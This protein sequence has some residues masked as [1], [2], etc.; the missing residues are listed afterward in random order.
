M[1]PERKR[2]LVQGV[3]IES[4]ASSDSYR[5]STLILNRSGK[6]QNVSVSLRN[7]P[8]TKGTIRLYTIDKKHNSYLDGANEKLTAQ[9]QWSDVT[10]SDWKWSGQMA[11]KS[12]L[13]IE[14]EDGTGASD[15]PSN[16]VAKIIRVNRYYPAR[17][18]RSYSDFDARTWI[19]RQGMN[20]E[21]LA[22]QQVGVTAKA[23][24]H[25]LVVRCTVNGQ[26]PRQDTNSLLGLRLDYDTARGYHKGVLFHGPWGGLDLYNARRTSPMAFGTRRRADQ[27]VKVPNIAEFRIQPAAYAPHDWNGR[28]TMTFLMQNAGPTV[29]VR[30][31]VRGQ[32]N[33]VFATN[34]G[35]HEAFGEFK[36]DS[37]FSGGN[38][39][40]VKDSINTTNVVDAAP[41]AVYQ[42]E[43]STRSFWH[44]TSGLKPYHIYKVRLH[45][46]EFFWTE[47]GRRLFNVAINGKTMLEHFDIVAAAGGD[48]RAVVREFF[49]AANAQ[50]NIHLH[51]TPVRD[52]TKISG[53]EVLDTLSPP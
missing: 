24:P 49:V 11:D 53:I 52:N 36:P 39:Y 25:V 30:W 42:S 7:V 50:G 18:T 31:T 23:L 41:S 29:S 10:I 3:P 34:A 44:T 28:V 1:P 43:R 26:L 27:V 47:T 8:F 22:D 14:A 45:W 32:S 15:S 21:Q 48:Q 6:A 35:S 19:A 17:G 5:A 16:A 38:L 2:V 9:H 40:G 51:F 4:V 12:T 37:G 33:R 20:G 13:Y 46:A